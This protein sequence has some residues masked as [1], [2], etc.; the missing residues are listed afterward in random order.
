VPFSYSDEVVK[1]I[2]DRCQELES[3]G[4]MIDAILTN[5]M[6]PEVSGEFLRRMMEGR[7]VDAVRID[8]KDGNFTY[9]FG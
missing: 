8:V 7:K 5:S 1:T 3:G 2:V 9:D 4:R 6:L